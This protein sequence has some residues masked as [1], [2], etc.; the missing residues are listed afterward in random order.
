ME[1][2]NLLT[3]NHFFMEYLALLNYLYTITATTRKRVIKNSSFFL[4]HNLTAL[5]NLLP[6]KR[7]TSAH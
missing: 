1:L 2:L 4:H 5:S 7:H 6:A 3:I